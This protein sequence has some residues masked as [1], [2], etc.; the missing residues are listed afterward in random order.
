MSM[1]PTRNY[2]AEYKGNCT[3]FIET[4]TYKGDS[5][6]LARDAGFEK[7]HTIDIVRRDELLLPPGCY[8]HLG[9]SPEVLA[10]LLPTI[11]EPYM[12]WL[13]AHSQMMEGEEDNYPLL[14]EIYVVF[15]QPYL[16]RVVIID[17]FLMM[18]HPDVTGFDGN[19][20]SDQFWSKG[21]KVDMLPNPI[22]NN[23][24]LAYL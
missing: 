15:K 10:R 20:I 14:K 16:P 11:K 8:F 24:L 6:L 5:A 1:H 19:E 9:D 4:G 21:Y 12:L 13:D 22:K 17:D 3:T 23:I 2:F 7:I 18:T